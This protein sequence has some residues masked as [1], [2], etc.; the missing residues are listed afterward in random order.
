MPTG[1]PSLD[2]QQARGQ[3]IFVFDFTRYMIAVSVTFAIVWLLRRTA[4]QRLFRW[5]HRAHH[6]SITPKLWAA[7]LPLHCARDPRNRWQLG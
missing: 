5:F 1:F 6:R 2:I 3:G 4:F 7:Y